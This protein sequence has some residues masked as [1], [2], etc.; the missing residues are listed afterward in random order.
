MI[1]Y[2]DRTK[3]KYLQQ[4]RMNILLNNECG[5]YMDTIGIALPGK[6]KKMLDD[7]NLL[8]AG[9]IPLTSGINACLVEYYSILNQLFYSCKAFYISFLRVTAVVLWYA[10]MKI[11]YGL[12]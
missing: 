12:K 9:S 11:E 1:L 8:C 2:L 7:K 4:G 3:P 5:K 6:H 10:R